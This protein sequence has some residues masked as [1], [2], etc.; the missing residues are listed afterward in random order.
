MAL[1]AER[2]EWRAWYTVGDSFVGGA[3]VPTHLILA[4]IAERLGLRASV[5]A[6][7]GRTRPGRALYLVEMSAR[8]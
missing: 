4:R 7:G 6:V 3:Y 2:L 5:R 1:L 8:A